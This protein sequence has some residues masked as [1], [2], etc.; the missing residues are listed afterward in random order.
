MNKVKI[1]V[2]GHVQGVGFRYTTLQVA[3]RLGIKGQVW[4]NDDGTVG[5]LAQAEDSSLLIKFEKKIR[6]NYG[7][8]PWIRVDYLDITTDHSPDFSDF[9][10]TY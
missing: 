8:R 10:L 1:I 7:H 5:I 6:D 4:N 2:S 3:K 9:S